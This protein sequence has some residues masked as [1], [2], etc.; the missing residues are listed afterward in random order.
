MRSVHVVR[1]S[2]VSVR[3]IGGALIRRRQRADPSALG[4][5]RIARSPFVHCRQIENQSNRPQC[6]LPGTSMPLNQLSGLGTYS[7][8]SIE[9]MVN[10]WQ[11]P[12][13]RGPR[14]QA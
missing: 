5:V 1:A 2:G 12:P 6:L 3:R 4:C 8:M 10:A 13:S 11:S 9:L 14:A 7:E